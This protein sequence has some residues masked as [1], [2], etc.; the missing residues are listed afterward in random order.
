MDVVSGAGFAAGLESGCSAGLRFGFPAGLGFGLETC[1]EVD[2]TPASEVGL[3]R[4][5]PSASEVDREVVPSKASVTALEDVPFVASDE[6]SDAGLGLGS[7]VRTQRSWLPGVK[8]TWAN[9]G[10]R[11]RKV[12]SKR[13]IE[14]ETSPATMRA[15]VRNEVWERF[16]SHSRFSW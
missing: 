13:G 1:S 11:I 5:L 14:S 9:L 6:G 7:D 10:R 16:W 15:S 4:V 8:N 12:S 3:E 2:V